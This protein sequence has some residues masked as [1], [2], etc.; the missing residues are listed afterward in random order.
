MAEA[1]ALIGADWGNTNLRLFCFD[2][3][4]KVTGV[5]NTPD[6]ILAVEDGAFEMA[7]E[8]LAG[9]WLE[10][11]PPILLCGAIGSRQGWREAPYVPCP[12]GEADLARALMPLP[13]RLGRA[14]IAAGVSALTPER[15]ETMRGEETKMLGALAAGFAGYVVSPGTHS[16]WVRLE[17][18]RITAIRSFMTGELFATLKTHSILG[19]L[20]EPGP[21]DP[22]AFE[23]G[24]RRSLADAAVTS[25]LLSSR[26]EVLLGRVSPRQAES[27]LSGVLIGAEVR[28]GL[29]EVGPETPVCLVG[30][31]ALAGL[32][33]R[34]MAL[35]GRAGVPISDGAQAAAEGLWRLGRGLVGTG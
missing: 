30:S 4:G 35:A 29:A 15:A 23:L 11:S 19:A 13:T 6:G 12:A 32:Y 21:D 17:A 7:L 34:A 14:W 3:T 10:D 8:A 18:G 28:A 9:D 27:F 5:R 26:A 33:A 22:A 2:A 25:L 20:M 31:D 24:V 1:A 16:K